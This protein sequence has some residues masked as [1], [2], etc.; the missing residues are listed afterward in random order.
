VDQPGR[1]TT[2]RL[3]ADLGTATPVWDAQGRGTPYL[4]AR[5]VEPP[6]RT[7]VS[8]F[9]PAAGEVLL[10]GTIVPV[11]DYGCQQQDRLLACVTP[12]DRLVV[13]DVG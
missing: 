1:R 7:S 6:G 9:D 8:S 5:T 11:L 3:L 10:R 13:T 12:D 2:G 4:V